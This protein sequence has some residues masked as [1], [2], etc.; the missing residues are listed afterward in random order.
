VGGVLLDIPQKIDHVGFAYASQAHKTQ[1]FTPGGR[2]DDK[3]NFIITIRGLIAWCDIAW[4]LGDT[5]LVYNLVKATHSSQVVPF[6]YF[7]NKGQDT[8]GCTIK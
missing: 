2:V 1:R 7:R 3:A 8:S 6:V 5:P 4:H